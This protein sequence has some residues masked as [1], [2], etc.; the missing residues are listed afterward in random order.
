METTR[1]QV[2]ANVRIRRIY[3]SDRL[4]CEEE[5]PTEYR[6]FVP[7][8]SSKEMPKKASADKGKTA[9]K[10][11]VTPLQLDDQPI[12]SGAPPTPAEPAEP[13]PECMTLNLSELS[14]L[15]N[16][17]TALLLEVFFKIEFSKSI[18]SSS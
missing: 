3:F 17:L 15:S 12:P 16:I 14:P 4:Y 8:K 2:H 1:V 13:S 9:G 7:S 5:M 11:E 18:F 6:L 10:D